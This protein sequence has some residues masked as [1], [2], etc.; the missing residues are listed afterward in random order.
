MSAEESRTLLAAEEYRQRG[1]VFLSLLE[2][3]STEYKR[4]AEEQCVR[5]DDVANFPPFVLLCFRQ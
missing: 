4:N 2:K 3:P 1:A 5:N